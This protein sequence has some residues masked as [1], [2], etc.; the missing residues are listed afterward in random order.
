MIDLFKPQ[1][2]FVV[3]GVAGGEA[4]V[5]AGAGLEVVAVAEESPEPAGAGA[6][7]ASVLL[8]FLLSPEGA[9]LAEE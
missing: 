1:F 2:L 7:A 8:S 9:G 4:G 3:P 6:E 5:D